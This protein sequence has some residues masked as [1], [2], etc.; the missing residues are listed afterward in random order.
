[1]LFQITVRYGGRY[2]RY[3]T[4][5]VEADDAREAMETGAE[6][7]SEDIASQVD[8]IELRVAVDPDSR[9]YEGED[10]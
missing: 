10:D 9:P 3:H 8:L 7:I 1:M 5:T 4:Y 6:E 2:Q